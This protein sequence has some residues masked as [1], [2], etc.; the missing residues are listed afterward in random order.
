M[1][2]KPTI[3]VQT[4][5]GTVMIDVNQN[6]TVSTQAVVSD[7]LQNVTT[8]DD[9]PIDVTNASLTV[10]STTENVDNVAKNVT[11]PHPE[12]EE[13]KQDDI[14][15]TKGRFVPGTSGN[16]NGRPKRDWTWKDLLEEVAEEYAMSKH[17]TSRH[18]FKKLVAKRLYTLA[19]GGNVHAIKDLMNRMDGMPQQDITSA[20]EHVGSVVVYK[21]QKNEE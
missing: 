8:S 7:N 14:R 1:E 21:P 11:Y 5:P 15:D 10:G 18:Q 20:G 12:T 9:K 13:R 17:G 2:E 6:G 16:P 3:T 4:T 19:V